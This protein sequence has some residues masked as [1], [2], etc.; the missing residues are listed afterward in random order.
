[1]DQ[2]VWWRDKCGPF[3]L[4]FKYVVGIHGVQFVRW[5]SGFVESWLEKWLSCFGE[6]LFIFFSYCISLVVDGWKWVGALYWFAIGA[7]SLILT[8]YPSH[9]KGF[10]RKK[11]NVLLLAII[12]VLFLYFFPNLYMC[13]IQIFRTYNHQI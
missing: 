3:W 2:H 5:W 9:R 12:L 13:F 11:P 10:S 6:I 7:C 4:I 1:M 8:S